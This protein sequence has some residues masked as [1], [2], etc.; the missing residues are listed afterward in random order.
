MGVY[1]SFKL[2]LLFLVKVEVEG[3]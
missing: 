1:S 2:D 3:E